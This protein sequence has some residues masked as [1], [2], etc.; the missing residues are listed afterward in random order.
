MHGRNIILKMTL[1]G[2]QLNDEGFGEIL[3]GIAVN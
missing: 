1:D 3:A 2:N